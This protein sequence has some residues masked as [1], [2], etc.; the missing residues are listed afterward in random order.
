MKII[1]W[2]KKNLAISLRVDFTNLL[3]SSIFL[4]LYI[5][6]QVT[7]YLIFKNSLA[8]NVFWVLI[9]PMLVILVLALIYLIPKRNNPNYSIYYL[10]HLSKISKIILLIGVLIIIILYFFAQCQ[11]YGSNIG[12]KCIQKWIIYSQNKVSTVN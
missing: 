3:T 5:V 7:L 10:F 4:P 1:D 12:M 2:I 8:Q 9:F 11:A 6:L